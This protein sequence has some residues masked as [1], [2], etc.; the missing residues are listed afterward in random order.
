MSP[1]KSRTITLTA[2]MSRF[3]DV[4]DVIRSRAEVDETLRDL[5][6]DYRLARETL[7]RIKKEKPRPTAKVAEYT[8]LVSDL[9]EEIIRYLLEPERKSRNP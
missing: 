4:A 9:E 3:A 8:N 5:C 6:E 1:S 7:L 2:A